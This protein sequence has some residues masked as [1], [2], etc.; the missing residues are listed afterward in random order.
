MGEQGDL[1]PGSHS[2]VEVGAEA[3]V[4][5]LAGHRLQL[6]LHAH[7]HRFVPDE[8]RRILS[9]PPMELFAAL[10]PML[11]VPLAYH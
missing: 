6:R 2:L 7:V 10:T 9:A 5:L 4:D 11:T 3:A 8:G 1:G